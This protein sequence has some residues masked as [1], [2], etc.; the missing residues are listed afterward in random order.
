MSGVAVISLIISGV[1]TSILISREDPTIVVEL[2]SEVIEEMKSELSMYS[3]MTSGEAGNSRINPVSNLISSISCCRSGAAVS[4]SDSVISEVALSELS[5][6]VVSVS[7]VSSSSV[8]S[9]SVK[10]SV[11]M[12]VSSS[13]L[14]SRSVMSMVLSRVLANSKIGGSVSVSSVLSAVFSASVVITA[15]SV[16]WS[17][18]STRSS[19][20]TSDVI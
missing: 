17:T 10:R 7:I 15:V 3:L 14:L 8:A 12:I 4:V 9:R 13:L 18:C 2:L 16:G 5:S 11:S 19:G 6:S 1:S 20:A